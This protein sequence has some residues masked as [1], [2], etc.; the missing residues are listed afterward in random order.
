MSRPSVRF[1]VFAMAAHD[2]P[3]E[4]TLYPGDLIGRMSSAAL[5]LNHP[6]VSEAHALLSLRGDH[7]ALLGLRGP[8]RVRGTTQATVPLQEGQRITLCEGIELAVLRVDLPEQALALIIGGA[9]PAVLSASV[10]AVLP[11]PPPRLSVG[12]DADAVAQVWSDASRVWIALPGGPPEEVVPGAAWIFS[13]VSVDG[14]LV[15]LRAA[16]TSPTWQTGRLRRPLT[17]V[18]RFDSA[19]IHQDGSELLTL[20]GLPARI[21]CELYAFG[22]PTLWRVVAGEVWK[23][24]EPDEVLRNRWDRNLAILRRRLR[25]ADVR[26]DLVRADGT[27]RF[28]LHLEA[29]DIVRD[30]M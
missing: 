16:S 2:G 3:S 27:G 12:F 8:L 4:L 23:D 20:S 1:R 6:N 28:E 29:D 25:E 10:Y 14:T 7:L 19:A 30:E 18:L 26:A 13:G 24:D 11:G 22:A 5:R 17:L 15:P 9:A 21:L